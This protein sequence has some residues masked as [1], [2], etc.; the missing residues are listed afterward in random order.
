MHH[1]PLDN[2]TA[3]AMKELQQRIDVAKIPASKLGE[4]ILLATW[5]VREL[6]KKR[7]LKTSLHLIAEIIGQFDLVT[8][9]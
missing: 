8:L 4:T 9:V 7:R 1:G 3:K 5:N 2:N 6:G